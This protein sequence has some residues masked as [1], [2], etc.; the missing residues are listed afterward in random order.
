MI[1]HFINKG[2]IQNGKVNKNAV[3]SSA[4]LHQFLKQALLNI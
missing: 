4:E 1:D 3:N 2:I